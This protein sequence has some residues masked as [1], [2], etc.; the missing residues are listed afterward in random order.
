MLLSLVPP[1]PLLVTGRK[2]E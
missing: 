1:R 2:C